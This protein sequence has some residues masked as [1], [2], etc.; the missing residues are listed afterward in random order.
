MPR[1]HKLSQ[2]VLEAA[3]DGLQVRRKQIDGQIAEV[4]RLLGPSV[5]TTAPAPALEA[6]KHGRRSRFSAATRRKMAEAQRRRW[7]A[8][9]E[10][11]QPPANAAK[12]AEKT[13]AAKKSTTP[14]ALAPKRRMSAAGRKAIAEAA[15]KRWV[16]F[17]RKAAAKT[18]AGKAVTKAP[19][20]PVKKPTVP[21]R[22]SKQA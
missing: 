14:E 2:E 5:R 1:P 11:Q 8:F 17:R 21:A 3:L 15:R 6:P 19:A 12:V 13:A 10:A 4:K 18:A 16:E 20:A 7:T 22:I 9:K